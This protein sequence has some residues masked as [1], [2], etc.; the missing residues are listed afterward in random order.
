M[1]KVIAILGKTIDQGNQKLKE[2]IG[3]MKY[4]NVKC[5]KYGSK[6][7]AELQDGTIYKVLP[8]NEGIRGYKFNKAIISELIDKN[9]LD[10]LVYPCMLYADNLEESIE[11]Y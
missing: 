5:L 6:L 1:E 2:I 4:K 8:A 7:E 10:N 11:W 9:I 3:E